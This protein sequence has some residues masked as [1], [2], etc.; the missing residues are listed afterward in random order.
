MARPNGGVIP[1]EEGLHL[2]RQSRRILGNTGA[3]ARSLPSMK[4]A[5]SEAAS[6]LWKSVRDQQVVLWLD[7]WYRKRFGTIQGLITDHNLV[8]H[9]ISLYCISLHA[10]FLNL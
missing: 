3:V 6:K 8:L 1:V 4:D 9:C 5:S 7:N 2:G 10:I